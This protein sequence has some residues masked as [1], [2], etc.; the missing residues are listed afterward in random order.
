MRIPLGLR[1]ASGL[2]VFSY[3]Y[4][5][6]V[7]AVSTSPTSNS[8]T[9]SD[10]DIGSPASDRLVVVSVGTI[11]G[12]GTGGRRLVSA[13]IGGVS[14]SIAGDNPFENQVNILVYAVIPTGTTATIA[15][16]FEGNSGSSLMAGSATIGTYALYGYNNS[17]P[18][19][20]GRD[21][22]VTTP[23][24]TIDTELGG[25]AIFC[26]GA[27]SNSTNVTW[28]GAT[29]DYDVT[30]ASTRKRSAAS[31]TTAS[32]TLTVSAVQATLSNAFL[33]GASWR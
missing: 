11:R 8:Y 15:L 21:S 6:Y 33:F 29:E 20:Y 7:Q 16:T 5:T 26:F 30:E 23:S 3:E 28:T 10:V 19:D 31:T 13:T 12:D 24:V 25:C 32:S 4:I 2:K 1:A 14:A 27:F 17:D 18:I 9:F 22:L